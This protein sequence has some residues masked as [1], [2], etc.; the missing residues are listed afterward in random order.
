MMPNRHPSIGSTNETLQNGFEETMALLQ[1]IKDAGYNIVSIWE[2]EFEK[3]L[4]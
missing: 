3:L 1:K 4:C 2:C